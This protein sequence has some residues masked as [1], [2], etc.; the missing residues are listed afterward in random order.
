MGSADA[1]RDAV[2]SARANT[3]HGAGRRAE[4]AIRARHDGPTTS[5]TRRTQREAVL[6]HGLDDVDALERAVPGGD[7]VERPDEVAVDDLTKKTA[8]EDRWRRPAPMVRRSPEDRAQADLAEPEP[9][10]VEARD[11]DG[12]DDERRPRRPPR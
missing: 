9:V 8:R 12:Q 3:S 6:V 1:E 5:P 7:A 4:P 10:H 11:D 2:D